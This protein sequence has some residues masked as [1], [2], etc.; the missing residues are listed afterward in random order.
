MQHSGSVFELIRRRP[1]LSALFWVKQAWQLFQKA[2]W[3]WIQLL[4]FVL[5]LNL[6]GSMNPVLFMVTLF[7]NPFIT[8][9]LYS[10]I[11]A[12]QRGE[13]ASFG[14]LFQ[15]L[16]ESQFRPLFLQLAALNLLLAI[17]LSLLGEHLT[18]QLAAEQ[19]DFSLVMLFVF[20]TAMVWMMFSYAVAIL[21]FLPEKRLL[22]ALMGSLVA[23]WRNLLPLLL[24]GV[25]ALAL[26][27]A[28]VPTMLLGMILVLPLLSIAFF[29]SFQDIF[30]VDPG[31]AGPSDP[32]NRPDPDVLEV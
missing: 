24:F 16:N 11:M 14:R 2:P 4:S 27:L 1:V 21:Y 6:L 3:L 28:T 17:P 30:D 5:L 19:L 32:Q 13:T 29:I 31:Q 22:P 7:L 10:V 25:I 9:G 8:A 18:Q 20:C 12:V 15:P 26:C 23:C